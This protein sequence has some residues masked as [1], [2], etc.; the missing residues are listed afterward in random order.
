M[1]YDNIKMIQLYVPT[2]LQRMYINYTVYGCNE[3]H[4]YS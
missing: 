2:R 3:C 4:F 1:Y